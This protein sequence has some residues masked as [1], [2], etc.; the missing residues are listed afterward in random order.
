MTAEQARKRED[1]VRA[2]FSGLRKREYRDDPPID[3]DEDG[4]DI[5]R[6]LREVGEFWKDGHGHVYFTRHA[7][8]E[9][10]RVGS[11]PRWR[12]P[13]FVGGLLN[14]PVRANRTREALDQIEERMRAKAPFATLILGDAL[15]DLLT[16]F[17]LRIRKPLKIAK[18]KHVGGRTDGPHK[19]KRC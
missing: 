13:R 1:E 18:K 19:R 10:Y 2:G 16:T 6:E 8:G 14:L 3:C 4:L 12:F 11:N 15:D 5:Y 17:P 9:D 7:D